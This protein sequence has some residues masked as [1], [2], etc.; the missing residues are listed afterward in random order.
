[1]Q[2]ISCISYKVYAA[3]QYFGICSGESQI[4][5]CRREEGG[6]GDSCSLIFNGIKYTSLVNLK[7]IFHTTSELNMQSLFVCSSTIHDNIAASIAAAA[8]V[9]VVVAVLV[10]PFF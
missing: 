6:A 8:V 1:M 7:A 10:V 9:A 4:T 2:N 3:V 5:E